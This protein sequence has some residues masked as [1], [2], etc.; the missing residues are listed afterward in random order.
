MSG[1]ESQGV[2]RATA[3][4][5]HPAA[6]LRARVEALRAT[7]RR[8]RWARDLA[9]ATA[10]TIAGGAVAWALSPSLAVALA[11]VLV[12]AATSAMLLLRARRRI[13]ASSADLAAWAEARATGSTGLRSAIELAASEP[14]R[15][16]VAAL[17]REMTG[18][19]A[20]LG[21]AVEGERR[22]LR[23]AWLAPGLAL[24]LCALAAG[25]GW[26]QLLPPDRAPAPPKPTQP[27]TVPTLVGDLRLT[28]TPPS[29]AEAAEPERLE[30]GDSA[31]ALEGSMV[32]ISASPLPGARGLT[33]EL[34]RPEL[35]P[36]SVTPRSLPGG[37]LGFGVMAKG[38]IAYR[39]VARRP[40]G[41]RVVEA[42]MRKLEARPDALPTATLVAPT[43][44]L[45][46]RSGEAVVIE[47]KVEDDLGLAG[48]D[49]V[50][51]RPG[52]GVEHRKVAITA[53]DRRVLV[54]ESVEVDRLELRAGELAT[55]WIEAR[56]AMPSEAPRLASSERLT[57][58]MFS[59]ERH[60]ARVLDRLGELVIA[61][62]H[63]LADRLE[64]DPALPDA[65]GK[66]RALPIA[67][68]NQALWARN[69]AGLLEQLHAVRQ[70]VAE[71][72]L[73][74]PQTGVDL[75][76]I[77][78]RLMRARDGEE[79]V[80]ARI[81]AG[82][83]DKA[84]ARELLR[85]GKPH[86]EMVV[87]TEETVIGLAALAA[88]E[89]RNALDRDGRA[90]E[91][92]DKRLE[93]VLAALQKDPD[94]PAL[95][96]EAERLIDAMASRIEQMA[97]EA[98][99]QLELLPPEHVNAAALD[100]AELD[101][102]LDARKS[103]LDRMREALRSGKP[104]DALAA[105]AESRA[106]LQQAM[107][108]LREQVDAERTAEDAALDRLVGELRAGVDAAKQ[109]QGG[110]REALRPTA[111]AQDRASGEQ[112][113]K[114]LQTA[115]PA[116]RDLL[117]DARDQIR[118]KRLASQAMRGSPAVAGARAA[119][120]EAVAALDR[121]D[122]D[123]ALMSLIEAEG[124]LG[125][126][127][128]DLIPKPEDPPLAARGREQDAMR[129][130]SARDRAARAAAAL[131]AAL[132]RP[133]ALHD[134]QTRRKLGELGKEQ[135]KIQRRLDKVRQRLAKE[136]S[137]QPGLDSQVGGR[138]DHAGQMMQKATEALGQGD[139][140][141]GQRR[142][143]DALSALDAA[144]E[145]LRRGNE[146]GGQPGPGGGRDRVGHGPPPRKMQVQSGN[147][148]DGGEA[149][150]KRLLDAARRRPPEGWSERV[151]R[152]YQRLQD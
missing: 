106:Q 47:G 56:D 87:A 39:F 116:I 127:R 140:S 29:Y 75:E 3:N 59:P 14:E 126:T 15:P 33:V 41:T 68:K 16:L 94:D 71:D 104:G 43:G 11:A 98:A 76:A 42:A 67:L 49:L 109:A 146:S 73:A 78:R 93:E 144:A 88:S 63:G 52:G 48:V 145:I 149:F 9:V 72:V 147:A 121:G 22:Q 77:E 24:A 148:N 2:A 124:K 50:I 119:L 66:R 120:S 64:G 103:A 17:C 152:Y 114:G 55:V 143:S 40:D 132:P 123:G 110:L 111:E 139:A 36:E 27:G 8:A 28:I 37:R 134:A 32:Q 44:E 95:R 19:V 82:A 101:G 23:R 38:E 79:R 30:E 61:W 53:G 137:R 130:A 131:R 20:A 51:A 141:T 86:A 129:V 80:V 138:I 65:N 112:L 97:A 81:D 25:L 26:L 31:R 12:L 89:H 91:A 7:E 18:P 99:R 54:R 100:P 115:M 108:A 1:V 46:V 6:T 4:P 136:A 135:R 113:K 118:P 69:E 74:R 45:E 35:P 5:G 10:L 128:E 70:M 125:Q 62:T 107:A 84:E 58:R 21:E 83:E 150:R 90:L 13:D 96:A 133:E 34:Q 151:R 122:I 85:M 92:L 60:H 102:A 105:L 142:M 57:L 117:D